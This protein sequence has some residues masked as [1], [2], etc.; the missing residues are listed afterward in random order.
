MTVA[1]VF[2]ERNEERSSRTGSRSADLK[3]AVRAV[4]VV[5]VLFGGC[6]MLPMLVVLLDR[7]LMFFVRPSAVDRRPPLPFGAS[8]TFSVFLR[9][10]A[11]RRQEPFKILPLARRNTAGPPHRGPGPR[12]E[13]RTRDICIRKAASLSV[14]PMTWRSTE[15]PPESSPSRR[16]YRFVKTRTC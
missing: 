7:C 13:V 9:R 3:A 10:H 5:V 2:L 8:E 1:D 16:S 12:T 6:E 4:S 11:E 15:S 14:Y